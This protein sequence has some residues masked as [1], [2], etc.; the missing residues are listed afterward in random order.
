MATQRSDSVSHVHITNSVSH[1]ASP[2]VAQLPACQRG[3]DRTR[4]P[5]EGYVTQE[6]VK[7]VGSESV[8]AEWA[9][10]RVIFAGLAGVYTNRQINKRKSWRASHGALR[11]RGITAPRPHPHLVSGA[12]ST[13]GETC[14]RP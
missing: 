11:H 9:P 1:S 6:S 4:R 3:E 2:C 12:L 10:G 7:A 13:P 5:R 8:G 14:P